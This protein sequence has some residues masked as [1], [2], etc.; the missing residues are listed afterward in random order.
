MKL[1]LQGVLSMCFVK[2]EKNFTTIL[3]RQQKGK[4]QLQ[5][6]LQSQLSKATKER[7]T[8]LVEEATESPNK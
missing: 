5:T 6:N 1:F 2:N 3:K 4:L 8:T 7:Q